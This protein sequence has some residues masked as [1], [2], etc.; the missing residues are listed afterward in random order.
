MAFLEWSDEYKVNIR[1]IDNEHRALFAMVNALHEAVQKGTAEAAIAAT[2]DALLR[3]TREH[4]PGEERYIAQSGYP[5]LARHQAEHEKFKRTI[6]RY[7]TQHD[8]NPERFDA[9]TL[10][11]YL[12]G[13]ITGHVLRSDKEIAPYLRGDV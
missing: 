2:L 9:D 11:N 1:V 10:L 3:Y 7:K 8:D 13:W 4:F 12:K 6:D 5:G